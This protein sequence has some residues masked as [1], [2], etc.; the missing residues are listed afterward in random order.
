MKE[1]FENFPTFSKILNLE[2]L[3]ERFKLHSKRYLDS[4]DHLDSSN[5]NIYRTVRRIA[6][7]APLNTILHPNRRQ[8]VG[9]K[10]HK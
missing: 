1:L 8:N 3:E 4:Q 10:Y 9:K 5:M 2:E 7:V 6:D